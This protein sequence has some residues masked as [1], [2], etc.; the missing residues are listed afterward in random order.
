MFLWTSWLARHT[1]K[2]GFILDDMLTFPDFDP[3]WL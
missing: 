3:A 1:Y 2:R